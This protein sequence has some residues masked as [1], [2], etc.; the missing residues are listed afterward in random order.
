MEKKDN[1]KGLCSTVIYKERGYW[2]QGW[3][4]KMCAHIPC[5][6]G[7]CDCV[8]HENPEHGK[9]V[10]VEVSW[11]W[12]QSFDGIKMTEFFLFLIP[13]IAASSLV[14]LL[15]LFVI[16]NSVALPASQELRTKNDWEWFASLSY[17]N[18]PF[19]YEC[20]P[21]IEIIKKN[22]L[23]QQTCM[24]FLINYLIRL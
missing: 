4:I 9:S 23:V 18:C 7:C 8:T 13:L 22:V 14:P 15:L 17:H 2:S 12:T 19:L 3:I 1:K 11:V 16:A 10:S 5:V 24:V 21:F 6:S 20:E